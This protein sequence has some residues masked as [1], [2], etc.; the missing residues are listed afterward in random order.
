MKEKAKTNPPV[1]PFEKGGVKPLFC[2]GEI[3]F[4]PFVKGE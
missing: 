2:M 4:P 1:S 3:K